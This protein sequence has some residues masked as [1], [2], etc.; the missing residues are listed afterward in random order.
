MEVSLSVIEG[1]MDTQG[2]RFLNSSETEVAAHII[3]SVAVIS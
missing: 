3:F 2:G 1:N